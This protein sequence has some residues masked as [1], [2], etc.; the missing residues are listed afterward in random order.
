M[1]FCPAANEYNLGPCSFAP[2]SSHLEVLS[3]TVPTWS[4]H[5]PAKSTLTLRIQG[6]CPF[7]FQEALPRALFGSCHTCTGLQHLELICQLFHLPCSARWFLVLRHHVVMCTQNQTPGLIYLF[8]IPQSA[9]HSARRMGDIQWIQ[10][11]GG[12]TKLCPHKTEVSWTLLDQS[13]AELGGEPGRFSPSCLIFSHGPVDFGVSGTRSKTAVALG[14]AL[15]TDCPIR[16][17]PIV[18][19]S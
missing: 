17:V 11:M 8:L 13:L 12:S 2:D 15:W 4:P 9:W 19:V 1:K 3:L 16:I 10:W 18:S 6:K 7:L 14:V 5:V